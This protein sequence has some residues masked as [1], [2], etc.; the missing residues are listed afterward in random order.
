LASG[1]LTTQLTANGATAG[2]DNIPING[3]VALRADRGL[4]NIEEVNLQTPATR[5]SATGQFS[6]QN[7]SNLQLDVAS[8]DAAEF[9]TVFLSSGLLPEVEEKLHEYG[10]GL[11][12]QLA[13]NGNIRGRLV[14]P[15]VNGRITLGSLLVNGTELGALSASIAMNDAEL[16]VADGQLS[17]RDGGGVHFSLIAPRSGENNASLDATLDRFS[18]RSVLALS[19]LSGNQRVTSDTEGDISGK[20]TISGIPNAMSG[21]ANLTL[22]PGRL[23]GEPLQGGGARATFNG[24]NVN[25]EN[26]DVRLGAGHIVASGNL[27]TTTK[28]FDLQGRA[29]GVQL[30]RLAALTSRP[31]VSSISGLAEFNAHVTGNFADRDF[32]RYQITFDGKATDVVVNGHPWL[33]RRR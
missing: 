7:D 8:T 22:G 17:E 15:E 30:D 4:F 28:E 32:S 25:I 1:S 18:A 20:I 19:P 24:P 5:L 10:V 26:V 23:A 27:N 31:G 16:R 2:P 33:C 14:S 3:T 9:Q 6:F 11:A 13:F 29:E 21:S 12:G